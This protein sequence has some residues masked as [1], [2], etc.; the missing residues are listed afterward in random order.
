MPHPGFWIRSVTSLKV[1]WGG[2]GPAAIPATSV[3]QQPLWQPGS[4]KLNAVIFPRPD[5]AR[6]IRSTFGRLAEDLRIFV[7]ISRRPRREGVTGLTAA[8]LQS[9]FLNA[10]PRC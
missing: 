2:G 7:Q 9:L 8:A 6:R 10:G 1:D 3:A 4:A 5:D